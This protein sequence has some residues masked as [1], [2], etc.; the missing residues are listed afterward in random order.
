MGLATLK[1]RSEFQRVRGGGRASSA[2]F[3]LEGKARTAPLAGGDIARFGF[4]ITKKLGNAV[5]RN[6]VRRRL[7][8]ALAEIANA[9]G[10]PRFD[11]VVVARPPSLDRPFADLKADLVAALRRVNGPQ[12]P[13]RVKPRPATQA[14]ESVAKPGELGDTWAGGR[15]S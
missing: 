9:F 5:V 1:K 6:R 11:Y 3:V 10:D 12:R 7:K 8:A 13:E 2:A 14:G 4:T 15:R